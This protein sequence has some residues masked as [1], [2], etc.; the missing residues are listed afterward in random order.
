M[1]RGPDGKCGHHQERPSWLPEGVDEEKCVRGWFRHQE[2]DVLEKIRGVCVTCV[3]DNGVVLSSKSL[4][5]FVYDF[6]AISHNIFF[7]LGRFLR[8]NFRPP[9]KRHAVPLRHYD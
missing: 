5:P 7:L 6:V 4:V 9:L 2:V 1:R 3:L 8:V